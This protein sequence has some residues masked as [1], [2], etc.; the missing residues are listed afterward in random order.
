MNRV[1]DVH[2]RLLV[3]PLAAMT[4]FIC[5]DIPWMYFIVSRTFSS[6]WCYTRINR[7]I[8]WT[9]FLAA[10]LL[11]V[12]FKSFPILSTDLRSKLYPGHGRTSKPISSKYLITVQA[13]W[14][15]MSCITTQL[16][17]G[18]IVL[19]VVAFLFTLHPGTGT[20]SYCLQLYLDG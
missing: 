15:G 6:L 9:L 19:T 4:A 10:I 3:P 5:H 12:V 18:T 2:S 1:I 20:R 11:I 7:S 8:S 14:K 17:L 16:H 13:V